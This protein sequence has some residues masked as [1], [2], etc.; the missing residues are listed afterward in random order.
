MKKRNL[1]YE[2]LFLALSCCGLSGCDILNSP[3]IEPVSN[4][5]GQIQAQIDSKK[6]E[7]ED[8]EKILKKFQQAGFKNFKIKFEGDIIL[9]L[10]ATENAID[11]VRINGISKFDKNTYF[12]VKS[13]VF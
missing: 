12:D 8:Y 3:E 2:T 9:G 13:V 5:A 4:N 1:V 6:C 7:D 10:F 11:S